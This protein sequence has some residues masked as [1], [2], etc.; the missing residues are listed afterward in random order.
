MIKKDWMLLKKNS[1]GNKST[2]MQRIVCPYSFHH[3][4]P[5]LGPKNT[6]L[7]TTS[8]KTD[9]MVVELYF[10][11]SSVKRNGDPV[12]TKRSQNTGCFIYFG[13]KYCLQIAME[14]LILL[15]FLNRCRKNTHTS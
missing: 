14:S 10:S 12:I 7:S 6:P 13:C 5:V 1:E 15:V 8:A 2:L 3:I 4:I 9:L 11:G